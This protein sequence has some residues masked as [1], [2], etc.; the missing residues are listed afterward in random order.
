VSG[1]VASAAGC[2]V[3]ELLSQDQTHRSV[4]SFMNSGEK[5]VEVSF[6]QT[7][8]RP[9]S[10]FCDHLAVLFFA[11][12]ALDLFDALRFNFASVGSSAVASTRSPS[13][14]KRSNKTARHPN[15]LCSLSAVISPS[16]PIQIKKPSFTESSLM[17]LI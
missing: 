8:Q 12:F 13:K 17:A 2:N 4:S 3:R 16:P 6:I 1:C 11:F 9:L 10:I 14:L 7:T 15:R 5:P